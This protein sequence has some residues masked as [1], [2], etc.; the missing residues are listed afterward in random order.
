METLD[1]DKFLKV[2]SSRHHY[3]PQFLINAFTNRQ[4]L[5]YIYDKKKDKILKNQR[6]PKS[7]FFESGRNT[8]EVTAEKKSSILEDYL[9]ND[10]D[11]KTSKS[12]KYFQSEE[13][14]KIDFKMEDTSTL[15]FF[16]ISL[17][18]RIPKTDYA[19]ED[20]MRRSIIKSDG[21]DPEVL[22]QDPT[23]QKMC[24]ASLFHHHVT[25]MK[26]FGRKVITWP[27]IHKYDSPMFV[28]GDYP[29]LHRTQPNMFREFGDIDLLFAVSSERLFSMTKVKKDKLSA[30]NSCSYNA[31]I[32]HQSVNYVA[33]GDLTIL[34][35]SI[36][37]YKNFKQRGLI[38][39]NEGA[40]TDK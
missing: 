8:I 15:L 14:K 24:R 5:L 20:L 36:D 23:Y 9:F 25:E 21:I 30:I 37:F 38:F 35:Q 1:L 4:G 34:K 7:I 33:S 18:W 17:F 39:F 6:P 19:V 2:N 13:L 29:F 31:A 40:F 22:R 16:L 26:S 10:M 11:N 27:N 32:I 3:I 12:I 28:I